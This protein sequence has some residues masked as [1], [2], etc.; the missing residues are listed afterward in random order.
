MKYLKLYRKGVE[1]N[2]LTHYQTTTFRLFKTERVCR[3]Q[4]Q[5]WRNWQ[6]VIQ[7]GR[8]HWEKEKL[9][10]M[11]NFSFPNSVFKRLVSQGHQ[12]VSL[13]GNGLKLVKGMFLVCWRNTVRKQGKEN[14]VSCI[15]SL[16]S[17]VCS[18]FKDQNHFIAT[19]PSADA[20]YF[21][22]I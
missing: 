8:K 10:F 17:N 13:C 1:I 5:I 16:S 14:V 4:F 7:M 21:Q 6:K 3:R 15:F 20:F 9:F 18:L 2:S 11:S 22:K 19:L 12:K